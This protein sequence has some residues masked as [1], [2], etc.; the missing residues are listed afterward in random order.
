[1]ESI[2]DDPHGF[3][4]GED[5]GEEKVEVA[6]AVSSDSAPDSKEAEKSS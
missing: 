3:K 6:G 1:M 2:I 5:D 4:P